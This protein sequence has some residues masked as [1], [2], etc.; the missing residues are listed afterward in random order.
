MPTL[1]SDSHGTPHAVAYS[2]DSLASNSMKSS[3]PHSGCREV[4]VSKTLDTTDPNPSKNQGGIAVV[5][6]LCL[7]DNIGGQAEYSWEGE[8]AP[9]LKATH[10]KSPPCVTTAGFCTEHSAQARGIGYQEECAP[11]LRAGVTPAVVYSV[12]NH[13][14]DS[15]VDIDESGKV[16]TLTSRMGTGG[17]NVP[18]VMEQ[19]VF[20]KGTRPH[21]TEEAQKWEDADVAN[22][23]NTFDQGEARA[24]ELV[25]EPVYCLQ[26]NGI[27][28][29]DTA[30]CNG[31][32]WREDASYTLNTVDRPA[33]AY[34]SSKA[35]FFT[36]SEENIASTLVA[37][38]YKDPQLCAYALDS[39]QYIVRR[40]TPTEC[41]RLQGFADRWGH[42]EKK[43]SF[44]DEEYRF[45]LDVRNAHAAING[46]VFKD[47]TVAQML[48]WYNKLWTDSAEYKMWGNGIALPPALYCMQGI[49]EAL[50]KQEDDDSW[51]N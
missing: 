28:R 24:N 13:P 31:A 35:S 29:A 42:I 9:T 27:D 45:W 5:Q 14:A 49:I 19:K 1:C 12:E 44:T 38:D 39:V 18:M 6:P 33:V 20:R 25:V 32:G 23:L 21:S 46:K 15:R 51:L 17:G 30:G 22:T 48:T 36:R 8:V 16:Q 47:Y 3:N 34:T 7:T 41:A 37:T 11:T 26:G 43:N 40:L 2:F 4:Q 10:Y 50:T